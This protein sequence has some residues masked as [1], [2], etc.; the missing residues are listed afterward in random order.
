MSDLLSPIELLSRTLQVASV[1][2]RTIAQNIANVNTPEYKRL[3]VEFEDELARVLREGSARDLGQV[4][5]RIVESDTGAERA[6]GNNV[7]LEQEMT[8][9]SK[10]SLLYTASAQFL[11]TRLAM[12]RSA[13]SG[14]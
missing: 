9:L 4:K 14:Q 5:P 12:L 11:A 7:T 8:D 10:N 6:D 2:H 3:E 1:R 13:V